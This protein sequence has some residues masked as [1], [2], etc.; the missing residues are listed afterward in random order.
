MTP[1]TPFLSVGSARVDITPPLTVPELGYPDERHTFF[2]GVHD[3]LFAKALVAGDGADRVALVSV[4]SIGLSRRAF[5]PGRDFIAEVRQRAEGMTGI[6][7]DHIMVAATH[8]HSTPE[9][10]AFRP[11][12]EHP[13]C[14]EWLEVLADQLAS[15]VALADRAKQ[16]A[17]MRVAQ[18]EAEGI[19]WS[20]RIIT[21]DGGIASYGARPADD[22]IADWGASDHA[23]TV[24][25]FERA[26]GGPTTPSGLQGKRTGLSGLQAALVH[27]TCHP[28]TVQVNP[29]V[30]ADFPGAATRIVEQALDLDTCVFVQG[31]CGSINPVR[32]T[33]GFGDVERYGQALAGEA[34]R[35]I[36]EA[37]RPDWPDCP[38]R[39][40]AAT[41]K[42]SLASRELPS[43]ADL[44]A[45]RDRAQGAGE[46]SHALYLDEQIARVE[47]GD[48]PF[49]A[50]VQA[51]RIGDL[52]IVGVEC[53][54]F[55]E[56]GL[57]IRDL[58]RQDC[59]PHATICA[60]YANGYLG[61]VAPRE[62]WA[63]GGYEVSLGMWAMVGPEAFGALAEAAEGLVRSLA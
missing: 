32:N 18:G 48:G 27:F 7:A 2:E 29:L 33:S 25:V 12:G 21:K 62:A 59:L 47:L 37:G 20:R 55:A 3:P 26:V 36:A 23:V 54:P 49:E 5:G 60:G 24:A 45:E 44:R 56:L 34:M 41:R 9:T 28:V 17:R 10:I 14:A 8:A 51:L 22:E 35:L 39:V 16:P 61:Y 50:E 30:S 63:Q 42:V 13:G 52:V 1:D 19:G 6:A 38:P 4:D 43:L 53:E 15:A 40:A 58:G 11:L 46:Q 57:A 31:A